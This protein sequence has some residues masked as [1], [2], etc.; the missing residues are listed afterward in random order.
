MKTTTKNYDYLYWNNTFTGEWYAIPRDKYMD[1][2]VGKK[3]K[4]D[5]VLCNAD[6]NVLLKTVKKPVKN[7]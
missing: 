2:F 6:L 7:A 5:G 4:V 1:F 3:K